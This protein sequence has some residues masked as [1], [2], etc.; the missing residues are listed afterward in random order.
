M[1]DKLC[2]GVSQPAVGARSML[3][4]QQL[5]YDKQGILKHT[6]NKVMYQSLDKNVTKTQKPT[7]LPKESSIP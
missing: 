3:I 4:K 5:V 6:Q 7:H 2:P 1:L